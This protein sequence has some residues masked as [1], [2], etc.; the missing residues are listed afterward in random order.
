M[1]TLQKQCPMIED[2]RLGNEVLETPML[3]GFDNK[4]KS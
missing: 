2:C 4:D 1:K 3:L